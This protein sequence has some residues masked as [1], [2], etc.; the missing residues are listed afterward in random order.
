MLIKINNYDLILIFS[1]I[2]MS[3]NVR[4]SLMTSWVKISI[5]CDQSIITDW[6][7][8]TEKDKKYDTFFLS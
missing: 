2:F 7:K 4:D 3:E 6:N 5:S 1:T 8:F